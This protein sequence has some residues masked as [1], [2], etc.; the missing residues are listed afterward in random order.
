MST[1]YPYKDLVLDRNGHNLSIR[2]LQ[3]LPG[4]DSSPIN[5]TFR[6][7]TLTS[8]SI[9]RFVALSYTWGAPPETKTILIDGI[10][11]R[12]RENLFEFLLQARKRERG[13]WGKREK[14]KWLWIDAVCINQANLRERNH[15]VQNMARI[16][17]NAWLVVVWLGLATPTSSAE[18]SYMHPQTL[19]RK[20]VKKRIP[21]H[22]PER[23]QD[24]RLDDLCSR[25]YW[26]RLWVVQ[27]I[28]L[29]RKLLV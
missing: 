7:V 2:L 24:L 12:V 23:I 4:E 14:W 29:A 21:G 15:Q 26:N 6:Q 17:S 22:P 18:I 10:Q 20:V 8:K 9:P 27:E 5:C 1:F 16:Y 25:D 19:H 3:L 11:F 13:H 28:L